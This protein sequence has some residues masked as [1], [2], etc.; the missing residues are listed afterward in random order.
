MSVV[1][2]KFLFVD[3]K[4]VLLSYFVDSNDCECDCVKLNALT[5]MF[6]LK[7]EKNRVK[8]IFFW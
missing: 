6:E 4:L 1:D 5:E 7:T 8:F 2:D 3:I